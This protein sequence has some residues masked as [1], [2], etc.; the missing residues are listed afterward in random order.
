MPTIKR[1]GAGRDASGVAHRVAPGDAAGESTGDRGAAAQDGSGRPG[2]DRP[3]D[4]GA[5][6]H[7]ERA[8]P[9]TADCTVA[10][11]RAGDD[12]GDAG[13]R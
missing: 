12:G 3:E 8:E 6:Q 11:R 5:D 4:D 13:Y 1:R 2:C 7:G 10:A 9:D